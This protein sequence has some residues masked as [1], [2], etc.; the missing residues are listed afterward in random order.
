[1]RGVA[2]RVLI[3]KTPVVAVCSSL[4][5]NLSGRP[6]KMTGESIVALSQDVDDSF[7]VMIISE[8]K[9]ETDLCQSGNPSLAKYV[10]PDSNSEGALLVPWCF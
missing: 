10:D 3:L 7:H 2:S 9:A 4:L 6:L 8:S 1:M 5:D